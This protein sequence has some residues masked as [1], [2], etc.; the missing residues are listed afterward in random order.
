MHG[1][2]AS[3]RLVE[4]AA[5]ARPSVTAADHEAELAAAGAHRGGRLTQ[6]LAKG[7]GIADCPII[8]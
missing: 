1:R 5:R 8:A 2:E 7:A 6:R 4:A 3:P